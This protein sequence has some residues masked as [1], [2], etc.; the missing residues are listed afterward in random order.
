MGEEKLHEV[1][2]NSSKAPKEQSES[3]FPVDR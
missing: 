3:V 2:A 1:W